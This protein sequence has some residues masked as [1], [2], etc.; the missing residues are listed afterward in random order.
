MGLSKA[1]ISKERARPTILGKVKVPPPSIHN[2]FE[3]YACLKIADFSII[4]KSQA[5]DKEKPAPAAIPLIAATT[6][7]FILLISTIAK[8][9]CEA[10]GWKDAP[11]ISENSEAT[12][13]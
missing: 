7:F 12:F 5:K 10:S 8:C 11:F 3:V 9:S 1:A 2:P 4:R 6:G 13:R